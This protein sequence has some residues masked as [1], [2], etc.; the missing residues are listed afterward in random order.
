MNGLPFS[1]LIMLAFGSIVLYGGLLYFLY[2][3]WK[4]QQKR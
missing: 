3:A 2:R 4:R 1:A